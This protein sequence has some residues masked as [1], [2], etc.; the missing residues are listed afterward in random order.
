MN[1][2]ESFLKGAT[3]R[4][5]DTAGSVN[6][7]KKAAE[8]KLQATG[9]TMRKNATQFAADVKKTGFHPMND[10]GI[11]GDVSKVIKEDD[12]RF[13]WATM[14]NKTRGVVMKDGSKK[15]VT[16]AQFQALKKDID[17]KKTPKLKGD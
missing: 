15:V 13:N 12:P 6:A 4:I 17:F 9:A 5:A 11:I 2:A 8:T 10:K 14:G 3:K 16:K 7:A 1:K